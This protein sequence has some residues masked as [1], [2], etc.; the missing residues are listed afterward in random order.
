MR[1]LRSLLL[2]ASAGV[3]LFASACGVTADTTAATIDGRS[4][5]TDD[6]AELSADPVFNGGTP[7]PNESTLDGGVAR[8]ALMFLIEREAWMAEAERWGLDIA[9]GERERFGTQIDQQMAQ[10]GTG[11]LRDRTRE[12]LIDYNVAGAAVAQRFAQLDP[13]D[14]DDL[15]LL[16]ESSQLQWRQ[17]CLTVVQ[18]P[19]GGIRTASEL[20][21]GGRGLDD[22]VER[23][24][25]A[26]QVADPSE[27][28]FAE[29]GLAPELRSDLADAPVGVNRGVV[30]TRGGP[31]GVSAFAYRLEGRQVVGFEDARGELAEAAAS[32][33]Q[34]GPEQFVQRNTLGAQ[35]DPRFGQQVASGS[36]G[37]TIEPPPVPALPLGQRIADAAAAAEAA[38]AEAAAAAVA[39][40]TGDPSAPSAPSAAAGGT[41]GS[42]G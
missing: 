12:L 41:A 23:I 30:L 37:F 16:Y 33:A 8:G 36:N 39:A 28:C 3:A 34:Q 9:D 29:V 38:A 32:L 11:T 35:I 7:A 31:G 20:I 4:I 1:S 2:A 18:I 25:G 5:S 14:D 17:V 24:E 26:E 27:G 22:L 19:A 10:Q 15:R 42:G 21:D 6:V 13:D 40:P